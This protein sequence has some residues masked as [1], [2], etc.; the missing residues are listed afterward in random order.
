[1]AGT[2][3]V[4]LEPE[5]VAGLNE[6]SKNSLQVL[7]LSRKTSASPSQRRDI[8]A[9]ISNDTFCVKVS[10]LLWPSKTCVPGKTSS[11][12]LAWALY[13]GYSHL[14]FFHRSPP[15]A[16]KYASTDRVISREKSDWYFRAQKA[17]SHSS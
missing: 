3:E 7:Q 14:G 17:A 11:L 5:T 12:L 8:M 4:F 9:Q 1:M 16:L 6:N 2:A 13:F 15:K 10:F